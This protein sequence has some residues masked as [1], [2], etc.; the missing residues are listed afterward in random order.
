[1]MRLEA[2]TSSCSIRWRCG[3]HQVDEL[4]QWK[5]SVRWPIWATLEI[6]D[7]ELIFAPFTSFL[8]SQLGRRP[9]TGC[10]GCNNNKQINCSSPTDHP[11][12]R[13]HHHSLVLLLVNDEDDHDEKNKRKNNNKNNNIFR[14]EPHKL[15]C[16]SQIATAMK[17]FTRLSL[18]PQQMLDQHNS[19][20]VLQISSSLQLNVCSADLL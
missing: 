3:F 14:C 11:H 10:C 19:R 9:S 16:T 8:C 2:A 20:L 18:R 15:Y 6:Q 4:T 12:H 1:M 5:L 7:A 17:C 13:P